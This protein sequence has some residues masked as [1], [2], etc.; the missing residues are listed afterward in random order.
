MQEAFDFTMERFI[1]YG[2]YP[3]AAPLV[4]D[5][6]RWAAYVSDALV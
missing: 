1:F 4:H 5:E 2:G 3:D 6:A